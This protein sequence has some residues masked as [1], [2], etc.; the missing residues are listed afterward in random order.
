MSITRRT[1][2]L[3]AASAATAGAASVAPAFAQA[4][5]P[6]KPLRWIVGTP[7][8][9]GSDILV[10]TVADQLS[11]QI[12]QTIVIENRPGGGTTIAAE[13]VARSA[14]DGY[15]L[16]A[17]DTGT[18]VFNTALF[19]KL[20]YK[21]MQ[22]LAPVGMLAHFP[23]LLVAGPNTGYTSAKA[24]IDAIRANPGR[25]GYATAGIGSPHHMAMEFLKE[26]AK[27]DTPH[28]PYKGGAP[29]IQDIV[30]GVVPL[31][32]VDSASSAGM[33][34]ANRLNV[35]ATF[36]ES[37]VAAVPGVPTLME[38]GYTNAPAPCWV[39]AVVPAGTPPD[40][41]AKLSTEI[42]KA[43]ASEPV[44]KRLRELA[45]EPQPSTAQQLKAT[46]QDADR[47]WPTLI[48]AKGIV[49]D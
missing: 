23:L 29:S 35:L 3:Y 45:L 43:V 30:A 20:S 12:N 36:T 39:S 28:V 46:W 33:R 24:A 32:V 40:V 22:D 8:G 37:R 5:F 2:G 41:V 34:A 26:Q 13:Y 11:K 47:K 16:L 6:S 44:Q 27:L 17:A 49:I 1:F 14:A 10:R 19:K 21:P 31:G 48:R 7:A 9:G 15:T 25:L 42:A 18:L 4:A 38:L